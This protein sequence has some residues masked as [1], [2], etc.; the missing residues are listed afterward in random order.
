MNTKLVLVTGATG[1]LGHHIVRVLR[2][3]NFDVVAFVRQGSEV[4]ALQQMGCRVVRGQ[5]SDEKKLHTIIA[6]CSYVIHC[7]SKTDQQCIDFSEYEAA[8]IETTKHLVEVCKKHPI[9]RFV[10]VSTANCFTS[11]SL[12]HPGKDDSR[13]MDFLR[14]SGYAYSKYLAQQHV[15][16]AAKNGFPAV[17][18]AP[19]FMVGPF[20][21]KPSSGRL[22][23]Y[24]LRNNIVFYPRGGKSFADVSAVATAVVN[25]LSQGRNGECYLLS[26]VNLSYKDY[27]AKI[28]NLSGQWKIFIPLPKWIPAL[29]DWLHAR[30]PGKKTMLLKTNIRMLF[31]DNYFSNTKAKS[32]LKMPETNIDHAILETIKWFNGQEMADTNP[33]L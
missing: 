4:G 6:S 14:N 23:L 21:A 24:A 12:D 3:R 9:K 15:F 11:G 2:Q 17:I 28:A 1:F 22:L 20:D 10:Y 26:G 8:N 5:L 18:V 27:F 32:I 19:A 13:F 30:F 31:S 7:A 29:L 16:E 33:K 25:A